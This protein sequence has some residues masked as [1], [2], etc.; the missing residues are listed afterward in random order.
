MVDYVANTAGG[1]LSGFFF[2]IGLFI[3]A[4]LVKALFHTGILG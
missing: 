4:V 3:A 1:V 2:G